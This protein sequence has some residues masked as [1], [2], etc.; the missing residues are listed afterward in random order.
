M[1]PRDDLRKMIN[2]A[3]KNQHKEVHMTDDAKQILANVAQHAA[4]AVYQGNLEL[5]EGEFEEGPATTT[6]TTSMPTET[7]TTTT[8]TSATTATSAA[9]VTGGEDLSNVSCLIHGT[10]LKFFSEILD[11][12]HIVPNPGDPVKHVLGYDETFNKGAFFSLILKCN[13]SK[14]IN[15]LCANDV[16]LVFSKNILNKYPYHISNAWVGGIQFEPSIPGKKRGS[17]EYAIKT[18][19]NITDYYSDNEKYICSYGNGGSIGTK[20]EVI[21]NDNI[22]LEDLIEIW[23]CD[24][25]RM[26]QRINTKKEDGAYTRENVNIDFDPPVIKQYVENLLTSKGL[27]IPVKII[28]NIPLRT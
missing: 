10:S 15:P 1:I 7:T 25:Q 12:N 23:I 27:N 20:N 28:Q 24:M 21:F 26:N 6:T 22:S 3:I 19:N 11:N 16:I 17:S 4:Q 13:E 18:Y 14:T 8:T 9:T 5:E 2:T